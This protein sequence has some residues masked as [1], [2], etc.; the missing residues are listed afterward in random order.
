[1][2]FVVAGIGI[3]VRQAEEDFSPAV[4]TLAISLFL[5]TG[6]LFR[7]A[8]LL[9]ALLHAFARRL[10]QPFAEVRE[11]WIADS[12]TLGQSLTL[13]TAD[14]PLEGHAI[15]LDVSGALQLRTANGEIKTITA[16]DTVMTPPANPAGPQL[17]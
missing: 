1:L 14:G 2:A 11:A 7:R 16:G 17:P 12:L 6:R 4:R 13:Q 3:N 5:A 8:D 10:N 9:V 15:G